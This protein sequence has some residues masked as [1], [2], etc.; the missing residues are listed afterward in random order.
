MKD[1]LLNGNVRGGTVNFNSNYPYV[2]KEEALL[3]NDFQENELFRKCEGKKIFF[4]E[5][6]HN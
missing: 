6:F 4:Y 2:V 5:A 3:D 1:N